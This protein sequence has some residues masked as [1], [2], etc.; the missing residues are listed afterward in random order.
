MFLALALLAGC[1]GGKGGRM[2]VKLPP[3]TPARIGAVERGVASWYGHPYHG[4][5][6]SN[7]E[8]Y[9][10]YGLTAAHL[11]LPF[12]TWLRVTN[13]ENGRSVEV[14]INDRGPFIKGRFLDLT[15]TAAE[16]L[17]MIGPGTTKV[18]A[19]V[20]AAP[21]MPA[22][23]PVPPDVTASV[24]E[25]PAAPID[26][27]VEPSPVEPPPLGQEPCAPETGWT[28]QLGAFRME[29]NA[30]RYR[31]RL[32]AEFPAMEPVVVTTSEENLH[33][34]TFGS[35]TTLEEARIRLAQLAMGGIEGVVVLKAFSC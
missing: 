25:V 34:V 23:P 1:G 27:P 6:T 18:E 14:R 26:A 15:F 35:F 32:Q 10:M 8:R 19:V 16:R 33:R 7:G 24:P 2:K 21:T 13:V 22:T 29:E 12:G 3:P 20:I 5:M 31:D 30:L 17:G 11:S 4:R 28:I 9:D